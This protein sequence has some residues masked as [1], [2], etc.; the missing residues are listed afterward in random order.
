MSW[1]LDFQSNMVLLCYGMVWYMVWYGMIWYGMVWYGIACYVLTAGKLYLSSRFSLDFF[2]FLFWV[3]DVPFPEL[4]SIV[5]V[6]KASPVWDANHEG[7]Y[8]VISF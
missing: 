1:L 5:E 2:V 3:L 4:S 6:S 7:R 8:W